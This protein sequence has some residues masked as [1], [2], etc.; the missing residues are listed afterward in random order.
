MQDSILDQIDNLVVESSEFTN[1][2]QIKRWSN[3]VATFLKTT[4]GEAQS[5]E[6]FIS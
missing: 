2:W 1:D 4:L 5:E 6:F 3:K